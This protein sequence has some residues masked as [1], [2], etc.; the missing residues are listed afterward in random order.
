MLFFLNS[1][2]YPLSRAWQLAERHGVQ[3]SGH[4][5]P[6]LRIAR[7]IEKTPFEI[8]NSTV[9]ITDPLAEVGL[10]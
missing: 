10:L 8:I 1:S 6:G 3:D 9:V 2:V 4:A 5:L 7:L